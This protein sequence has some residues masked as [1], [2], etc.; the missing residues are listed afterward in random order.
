[1]AF[2]EAVAG[3]SRVQALLAHL[4]LAGKSEPHSSLEVRG[5][6]QICVLFNQNIKRLQCKRIRKKTN[7]GGIASAGEHEDHWSDSTIYREKGNVPRVHSFPRVSMA[8]E[9]IINIQWLGQ[10]VIAVM[11]PQTS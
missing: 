6:F 3:V 2:L 5:S 10:Y 11:E 4:N 8:R 9:T 1:M 7:V